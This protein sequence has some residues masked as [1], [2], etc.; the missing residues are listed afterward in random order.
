VDLSIS[1]CTTGKLDLLLEISRATFIDTFKHLNDPEDFKTYLAEAFDREKIEYELKNTEIFYFLVYKGAIPVGYFKLNA[2]SAQTDISDPD[3]LEIER[4]YLCKEYQ[5]MKIG[6]WMITNIIKLARNGGIDYLWL[7]VWEE[8]KDAI[9]FYERLG[10]RKFKEHPFYI[11]KD[12]QTDW[13]MR[14]DIPKL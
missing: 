14:F 10:F 3:S 2:A 11:G 9:R 12:K 8:N 1:K 6:K 4:I 13:L 7:S 5:G